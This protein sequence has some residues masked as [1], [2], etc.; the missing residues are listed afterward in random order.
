MTVLVL[1]I[2]RLALLVGSVSTL[3]LAQPGFSQGLTLGLASGSASRGGTAAL[4]LSLASASPAPAGLQWTMTYSA[5]DITAVNVQ[6]GPAAQSAGKSV[7]C[8]STKP[9]AYMCLLEGS[10]A[11]TIGAGVAAV[12]TFTVSPS[13]TSQQSAIQVTNPSGADASGSPLA[14]TAT[15]GAI[16]ITGVVTGGG[17]GSSSGGS[18]AGITSAAFVKTDTTTQGSWKGV[19]GTNGEVITND[20]S[21]V[22]SFAQVAFANANPYT[23][24][25][26]TSDSRAL[27]KAAASDCLAS[28]WFN[29]NVFTVDVNLTDGNSH[30]VSIYCLDWDNRSRAEWIDILDASSG[31]VLDSRSIASFTN[32]QYLMWNLS[33]HLTIRVTK[34]GGDNA[35]V[36]GVFF[37]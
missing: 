28:T 22:P 14:A 21:N 7:M 26:S 2:R 1:S 30:P 24:A 13:T 18:T 25:A 23:W 5:A 37:N 33:G 10:N 19:Y 27:Q 34:I 35:V 16:S 31:K 3:L 29:D 12:A 15:G 32:G 20:S 8:A 4:N 17:S 9:G 6:A 11:K 36:S